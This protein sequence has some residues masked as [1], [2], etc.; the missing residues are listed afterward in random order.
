MARKE[1]GVK[2]HTARSFFIVLHIKKPLWIWH[3]RAL[4][5]KSAR[6][7]RDLMKAEEIDAAKKSAAALSTRTNSKKKRNKK[8]ALQRHNPAMP[9]IDELSVCNLSEVSLHEIKASGSN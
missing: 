8:V 6:I 5:L 4:E 7:A 3:N 2:F 9:E 1:R